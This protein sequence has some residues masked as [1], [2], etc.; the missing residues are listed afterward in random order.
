ME[1]VVFYKSYIGKV[2]GIKEYCISLA[3]EAQQML[4]TYK[5]IGKLFDTYAADLPGYRLVKKQ[6]YYGKTLDE[7]LK[8]EVYTRRWAQT[9]QE[10]TLKI[11]QQR[12][13]EQYDKRRIGA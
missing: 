1:R 9:L 7:V 6:F 10:R 11:F 4:T 13:K 5:E 8:T 3:T 12:V 2:D